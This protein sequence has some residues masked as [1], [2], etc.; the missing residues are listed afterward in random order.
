MSGRIEKKVNPGVP[1]DNIKAPFLAL[2]RNLPTIRPYANDNPKY[3]AKTSSYG[4]SNFAILNYDI[5]GREEETYRVVQLNFNVEYE[6]LKGLKAKGLFSYFYSQKYSDIHEYTYKLYSYDE[7]TDTYPVAFSMD[8]PFMTRNIYRKEELKG[9]LQLT[10]ET[11]INNHEI[12]AVVGAESF[13]K[14]NPEFYIHSIPPSNSINL[15]DYQSIDVFTDNGNRTEARLGY[16][17]RLN[18]NYLKKYLFEASM[19]YDGSWKFPPNHRWGFFPS[20]SA[21][22]RMS[23]E[24]FWH[25]SKFSS[26]FSDAKIRASYGLLGDDNVSN[27]NAF[28]YMDGYNYYKTG[29][30]INGAYYIGAEP[31]GLPIK[32]ISWIKAKI[33]D[34]GIDFGFL[35]NQFTGSLDYFNRNRTGLPDSRYDVLIPGEVGFDL[36]KENLNSDLHRGVD[37]SLVWRKF[38]GDFKYSIGG[39]FTYSRFY[40][41]HKYKPRHGNS[42]DQYRN[43]TNERFGNISWGYEA[44]GQFKSWEE[45]ATYPIDN[46]RQGNKTLRPGDIKYKDVNNDN[47]INSM[48]ARPIGYAEGALPLLN[49]GL[50]FSFQW[51]NFDLAFDLTGSSFATWTQDR[52]LRIPFTNAGNSPQYTMEDQWHLSDLNNPDSELIP[53]KYPTMLV[54]KD[55]HS[56]YWGSTFWVHNV[57]YVKL[58]NF[59][60]GYTIPLKV[61]QKTGLKDMRVYVSGQNLF[62]ITNVNGIDPEITSNSGIQYPTTRVVNL[63]VNIKF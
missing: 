36:P 21:G 39:N 17:G 62:Y 50:N 5:S 24:E 14:D 16:I 42:W 61:L 33:F 15:F 4:D 12:S 44:I 20:V 28:D 40:N 41:W 2:Y 3:P 22:W 45:I 30:V 7:A 1:G 38:T 46:D 19:R 23:E 10:Y 18:Y 6:L 47:I 55:S 56:N 13:K 54:G 29:S 11:K 43:S 9:Q 63:G 8:N 32:N 49:Y 25:N 27:Y 37:G 35:N 34:V 60:F 53:G 26:I 48:D 57:N 52:E 59:Q 58:R 51:K 31:R